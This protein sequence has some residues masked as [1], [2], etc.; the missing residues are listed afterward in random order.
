MLAALI[1]QLFQE[2][3]QLP[4]TVKA[5]YDKHRDRQTKP[6]MEELGTLLQSLVKLHRRV[7][8]VIDAL[9]ECQNT[10]RQRDRLLDEIVSL[11]HS[12]GN[13]VSML[14]TTR[15]VPEILER[16]SRCPQIEISASESDLEIYL[17]D[18]MT[19]LADFVAKETGLQEEIKRCIVGAAKGM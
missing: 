14:A 15:F 16:F 9:D 6:T 19:T 8:I 18:R 17:A 1:R 10:S 13:Y 2:Q 5:L 4:V 11:Q 7:Y 3:V 12:D